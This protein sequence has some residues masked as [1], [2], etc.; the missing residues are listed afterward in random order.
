L[1]K[2]LQ[3]I[4]DGIETFC[5]A[6][7]QPMTTSN[8]LVTHCPIHTR[9]VASIISDQK[10]QCLVKVGQ[11]L[12]IA[13]IPSIISDQK[14]QCLVKVG[15]VQNIVPIPSINSYDA[16]PLAELDKSDTELTLRMGHKWV[17]HLWTILHSLYV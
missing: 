2:G 6:T 17:H 15:Q 13:L 5:L 9:S 1:P 4:I 16:S 3:E 10:V 12:N 8:S 14:V 7:G 11:V